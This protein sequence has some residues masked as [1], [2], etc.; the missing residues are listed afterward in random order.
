MCIRDRHTYPRPGTDPF[1]GK[2]LTIESVGSASHTAT[3]ATYNPSTGEMV[4]TSN[5][6]NFEAPTTYSPSNAVYN[7]TTGVMTLTITAHGLDNGDFIKIADNSLTFTCAQDGN[8][9]EKTYP[10]STDPAS[11]SNLPISN[12]TANTFDVQ[13]LSITPSTNTT[14]HTFVPGTENNNCVS[15]GGDYVQFADDLSLIHI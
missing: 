14:A 9:V 10:R 12:V 2:S 6:H 11:G 8:T 5:A 1:A 13:V 4:V 15:T 7:P 3:D